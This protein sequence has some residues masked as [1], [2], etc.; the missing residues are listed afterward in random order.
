MRTFALLVLVGCRAEPAAKLDTSVD[1]AVLDVDG[2][3]FS[4]AEGDCDDDDATVNPAMRESCDGRDEDC[5]GEPDDGA[6]RVWHADADGDDHGDAGSSVT[7]CEAPPAHIEDGTDC[8]D[9]DATVHPDA[10]EACDSVDNDCDGV[11]D[12]DVGLPAWPD[13]DGDGFGDDEGLAMVCSLPAGWVEQAGDCDDNNDEA[14]P[15]HEEACDEEDND[16]DGFVDEEVTRTAWLDMDGDGWGDAGGTVEACVTPVGYAERDGDCDDLD[17]LVN[18]DGLEVCDARDND[19]DGLVD[20]ADATVTGAPSWHPDVDGDGYGDRETVVMACVAPTGHL[21]DG[22]DCD[23]ARAAVHPSAVE[24][25]NGFDDDCDGLV[26]DADTAV[27]GRTRGYEDA[28]EDG[29][30][31]ADAPLDACVLPE[32]YL[33]TADDCDD[34]DDDVFPGAVETADGADED[35]DGTVDEGT[36]AYD[37]DGDGFAERTGDCDDTDTD[38]RP[39]ATETLDGVDEDCDGTVD[40]GTAGYDDDGDGYTE[41][42]GDCDDADPGV[43][44]AAAETPDGVDEDCDGLTDEG[45]TVYDDDGD[46]FAEVAGDCDDTDRGT[47]PGAIETPDGVDEDCDGVVDDGTSARDDEG[48]GFAE[49]AGDC[50]DADPDVH[51][52]ATET[53]DGVDEDCDGLTDEGTIAYDDDGDGAAEVAGDCDDTDASVRPGATETPDGVDEDCDGLTDEGTI[54]YDDDGDGV[55]EAGGDCDDARTSVRPGAAEVLDGV[56][57]DCDGTVDDGVRPYNATLFDAFSPSANPN[58]AWSY[59]YAGSPGA[60]LSRFDAYNG[61]TG[62]AGVDAWYAS[63]YGVDPNFNR[64]SGYGAAFHP[65]GIVWPARSVSLHPGPGGEY[66]CVAWTAPFVGTC[67]LSVTFTTLH[68]GSTT[69][70]VHHGATS[71]GSAALAGGGD[72]ATLGGTR[73][74]TTGDTLITCVGANGSYVADT[75]G[76]AGGVSC[77]Y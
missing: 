67:T 1:T 36:S 49:S 19:C 35:C 62:I 72:S 6:T 26:D 51:P 17:T 31:D 70:H 76:V 30:A 33:A 54:A 24:A 74:V 10:Q 40:E 56:D 53:P 7:A 60:A 77:T 43:Y 57:Q 8:D 21:A 68:G 3:G 25:C 50:D 5:D 73:G 4:T 32:G 2:D 15:G 27:V 66:A 38:V 55:S 9:G 48:D 28:D 47:F 23:D 44:P 41:A 65:A 16:C 46:G 13:A 37:D 29:H 52:G 75:T 42:A 63:A 61:S 39:G 11:T 20:D 12:E 71:L 59:G 64:N 18:P 14:W 22:R 69:A 58:G 45:T 34:R